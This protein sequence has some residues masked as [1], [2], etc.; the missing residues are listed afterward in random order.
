[1]IN[2]IEALLASRRDEFGWTTV[3]FETQDDSEFL[4]VMV[5]VA[6][7]ESAKNAAGRQ[8]AYEVLDTR[9]PPKLDGE[10]SWMVVFQINGTVVDSVMH[11]I[12]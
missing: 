3:S 1:V 9:I 12:V 5:G 4:L 2:E 6:N 8:F 10:Y 7:E 11:G